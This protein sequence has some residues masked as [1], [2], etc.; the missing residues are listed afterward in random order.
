MVKIVWE[1]GAGH[2]SQG[3]NIGIG[4]NIKNLDVE[5]MKGENRGHGQEGDRK[6]WSSEQGR[7]D[8]CRKN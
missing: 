8:L 7:R 4:E 5:A 2:K 6:M 3:N 1:G